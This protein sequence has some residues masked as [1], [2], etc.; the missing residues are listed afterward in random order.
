MADQWTDRLSDY[1]D[2]D[3]PADERRS[4]EAH[5]TECRDC[6]DTMRELRAVV[7]RAASLRSTGPATDLWPGIEAR[8]APPRSAAFRIAVPFAHAVGGSRSRCRSLIA[9]GLALM[10]MSGGAV[11]LSQFGGR[12]TSLPPVAATAQVNPD[13]PAVTPVGLTNPRYDDG[14]SRSRRGARRRTHRSSIPETIKIL[15][16]NLARQSIRR[17][18]SRGTR[19][20]RSGEHLSLQ[21]SRRGAAAQARAA[22]PRDRAGEPER[23]AGDT[24][25]VSDSTLALTLAQAAPAPP[26]AAAGQTDQTVPVQRGGRLTINNFAGEVVI[27]TWGKDSLH[28]VARH[29]SRTQGQHPSDRRRHDGQRIGLDGAGRVG[30]LRHHRAGVDADQGRRQ[31]NFITIDGAQAEVSA[32]SVR[33]D[34]TIKGGTGFVTAKTIEGEIV[35]E[36]ARGKVNV[37]S[38]NRESGSPTPAATSPPRASTGRSR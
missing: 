29:Q 16:A 12:A 28:V 10:V 34:I 1:L 9:A 26:A 37:S 33:G 8:V 13:A 23:I 17:S 24:T 32:D 18:N 27:H 22:A 25:H 2:D 31:F 6:A 11:W 30:R 19:S 35:V 21:P 15:E 14:D 38:V 36:G 20:R 4:L 5:L 7:A 3:L